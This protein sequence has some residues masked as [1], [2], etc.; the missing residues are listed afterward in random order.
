MASTPSVANYPLRIMWID[1]MPPSTEPAA[2]NDLKLSIG[3]VTRLMA[4][5]S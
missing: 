2:R 4:R 3:L 1:S 5:W